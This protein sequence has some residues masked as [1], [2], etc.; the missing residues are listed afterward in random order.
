MNTVDIVLL[1]VLLV[2]VVVGMW[3]GLVYEVLS[4]AAWVAA[5]VLAQAHADRAAQLLPLG[6][7]SPAVRMAIGFAAVFVACA[8]AGG[9]L[10]WVVKRLVA[11]VGLRPIDRVLGGAFGLLRGAVVLLAVTVVVGLTPLREQ[12]GWKS[13]QVA[14]MLGDGLHT[15][16]PLLPEPVARHLS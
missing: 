1:L 2:S 9:L 12:A 6:D 11:A 7:L 4:V 15:L 5:F 16:R 10:A 13:S 3:R 14:R 8:F